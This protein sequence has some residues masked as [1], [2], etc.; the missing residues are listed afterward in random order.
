MAKNVLERKASS[1]CQYA[2]SQ[3]VLI[4]LALAQ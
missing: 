1:L 3:D 2:P 4:P